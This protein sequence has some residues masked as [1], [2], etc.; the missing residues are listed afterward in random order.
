MQV[1]RRPL[2][3]SVLLIAALHLGANWSAGQAERSS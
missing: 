2:V 3:L 1:R